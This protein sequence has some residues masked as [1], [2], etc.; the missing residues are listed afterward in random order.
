MISGLFIA[1]K[2]GI[3]HRDISLNNIIL[4]K[5]FDEYKLI[6]FG[7][8]L[9]FLDNLEDS[10][11]VGKFNY[12]SPEI[13]DLVQQ[14]QGGKFWDIQV[15]YNV[16]KADVYSL[17]IALIDLCL[18]SKING[19]SYSDVTISLKKIETEYPRVY[20]IVREMVQ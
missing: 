4:S 12:M 15:K 8:G 9:H 11:I 20:S 17:G 3:N 14:I 13:C 18:L 10:P 1:S 5:D 16:E 19:S 7:E 6:D 2:Y